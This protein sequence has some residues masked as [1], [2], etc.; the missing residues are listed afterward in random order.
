MRPAT[1]LS[2]VSLILIVKAILIGWVTWGRAQMLG[3]ESSAGHAGL[4]IATVALTIAVVC[5]VT[6]LVLRRRD[7]RE[8]A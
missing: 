8:D 6:G 7:R 5:G 2:I 1:A 3:V 4:T